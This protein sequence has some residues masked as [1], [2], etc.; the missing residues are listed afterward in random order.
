MRD[1]DAS[2]PMT[3]LSPSP[4]TAPVERASTLN[5]P[6]V[7]NAFN[8]E[9]IAE[10][11]RVGRGVAGRCRACASSCSAAPAR[12]SAPA[13]TSTGWRGWSAT[14]TRRTCATREARRAMF[15]ALDALP[16]PLIGR[17]HGAALGGGAGLAA[18]CDI[19]V[20]A[21]DAHVRLHRGEARHPAGGDLAVRRSPR[22]AR[23]RRASCSSPAA[24]FGAA[25]ARRSASST[26][27]CPDGDLDASVDG[28]VA[29]AADVRARRRRRREGADRAG[30]RPDRRADVADLT[31]EA[32]ARAARVGRRPGRHARVPREAAGT[33]D[34]RWRVSAPRPEARARRQP[35]R[36][37]GAHHPRLPRGRHRDAW[38]STP[39][40]MRAR[41]TSRRP[42]APCASG[43]RRRRE[44]YLYIDAILDAARRSGADAVHPG[45][46]LPVRARR[47]SPA[48]CEDAG[49]TFVGPPADGDR[50]H[51]LEDRRA[52]ADGAAPA[53]R[54]CPARRRRIRPTRRSPP[55]RARIGF[56][57]LVK[58]VG[59][60]RRQGHA[61]RPRAR[62]TLPRRSPRRGA[63][64][65]AAFGD[66]TL[67]VERLIERPRH[68][69]IQVF[70]DDHG[71]VVHLFER[72]CSLQRRHQKVVEESPS[73]AL[74]PAL[75]A[76]MG[77]AA[78][79][80]AARGRL[81]QRRHDRVPARRRGRRGAVLLP[82]DEHAAAGRASGHRG[83]HRRRSGAA[84]SWRSRPARRCRGRR[85]RCAQRGHAIECRIYAEDP[86][87]DF[88][89]QAGPLLLYREPAGPGHPRR[90]RRRR[91][92]RDRR[93]LRP[94]LAKLIAV[95]ETRRCGAAARHRGAARVSDPRHPHQHPVPAA[96]A[97]S[98][99]TSSAAPHIRH[100]STN[101]WPSSTT[102][103]QPSAAAIA[104][105]AIAGRAGVRD[106][107]ARVDR[108]RPAI[109]RP[110]DAPR[111]LGPLT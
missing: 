77:A 34:A 3:C 76:R 96:S 108:R 30:R 47:I 83:G 111:E 99:P 101:A 51:G 36:D 8:E 60:R 98:I 16:V 61:R 58:A 21:D 46:R 95:A 38:R 24:R 25:R 102:P 35:R 70:G 92:R 94:L 75:R 106:P 87:S 20:A 4:S 100:F 22:S 6:D 69:E 39:T 55:R 71:N 74:T 44:S 32:I 27:S 42:I 67:Y 54:S 82:R 43:R 109:R 59:R 40:P 15:A 86:A 73:P 85:S 17:I 81:P 105:A 68:V 65:T 28:Y 2:I 56:P 5:R 29:R 14:R 37:R 50:A 84:R 33:V 41:C 48:P 110:L 1:V 11:T 45:L 49:L 18:V 91:G 31:A 89:P 80:A 90:R 78:V 62:T 104:A 10:L 66:G 88:L 64:R 72:E 52:R 53:C 103:A 12:C 19:V 79:A 13:P 57:V 23:R 63:R 107:R 9:V 7:R 97:R 93:Q 26:R